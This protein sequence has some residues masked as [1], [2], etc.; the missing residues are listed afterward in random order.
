MRRTNIYLP[1]EQLE[2][3]KLLSEQRGSAVATLV[4]EALDDWLKKQGVRPVGEDE[5]QRRFEA[6]LGRRDKLAQEHGW[7]EEDVE[8]DVMDA[9]RQVRKA[10]TA[11]RR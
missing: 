5:W 10:R 11:R 8:R 2:L 4:R 9:V 7:S 6:L 3:L 1:D